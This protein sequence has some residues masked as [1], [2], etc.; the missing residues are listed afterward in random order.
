VV[1]QALGALLAAALNQ[2]MWLSCCTKAHYANHTA[3]N[4]LFVTA[5]A[6][7][8]LAAAA[9]AAAVTV[10]NPF[11]PVQAKTWAHQANLSLG[12]RFGHAADQ[13]NR[14]S[15]EDRYQHLSTAAQR[16]PFLT[17]HMLSLPKTVS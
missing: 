12:L 13:G 14:E 7:S 5:T 15:M 10:I 17:A 9:A 1:A 16:Q 8:S 3:C 11:A 2:H 4:Y 6:P